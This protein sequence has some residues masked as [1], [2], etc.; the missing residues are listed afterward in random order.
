MAG[1]AAR[2]LLTLAA[3]AETER[4]A[5]RKKCDV[6]CADQAP[7][8]A[9]DG[10]RKANFIVYIESMPG[11][12]AATNRDALFDAAV[13]LF[14]R[15]GFRN[16]SH[17]DVAY[18][19]GI[20]RTTFYDY[21]SSTED[22]LVQLVEA[23]L[24]EL[25]SD[26]L[27]EIPP[28]LDPQSRLQALVNAMIEFVGTDHL[29][30]ILHT[31]VATLSLDAQQRI[32]T[33]HGDLLRAFA[34]VYQKGIETGVFVAMPG[35]LASRL[36]YEVI[37]AAGRELMTLDDPKQHVHEIAEAATGFVLSGISS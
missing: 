9:D 15:V 25:V 3:S 4:C 21:F 17:A 33:S 11:R 18:A 32:A 37:M 31:E 13:D 29:G 7:R 6:H 5:A 12:R 20:G 28:E 16:T 2:T 22:L 8:G 19:A 23:R 30:L 10:K 26:L 36:I 24:P 1:E 14:V 27:E 34:E 35:R